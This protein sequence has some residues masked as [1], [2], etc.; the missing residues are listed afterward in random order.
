LR[1]GSGIVGANFGV[2]ADT[3]ADAAID[4]RGE[5]LE[6]EEGRSEAGSRTVDVCFEACG[7]F[8][9]NGIFGLVECIF[10]V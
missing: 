6:A 10:S 7:E 4:D 3:D 8:L 2:D 5:V 9:E 1:A